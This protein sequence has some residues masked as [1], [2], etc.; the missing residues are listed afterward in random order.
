MRG[1]TRTRARTTGRT[2]G[3]ADNPER[4][5]AQG[6]NDRRVLPVLI[7]PGIGDTDR[8]RERSPEAGST[9]RT[10]GSVAFQICLLLPL[11]RRDH[12]DEKYRGADAIDQQA[13][14][15]GRAEMLADADGGNARV[16][17][18][19]AARKARDRKRVRRDGRERFERPPTEREIEPTGLIDGGRRGSEARRPFSRGIRRDSGGCR[20]PSVTTP[21]AAWLNERGSRPKSYEVPRVHPPIGSKPA[22][23][24]NPMSAAG[25]HEG[26]TRVA[27]PGCGVRGD[28]SGTSRARNGRDE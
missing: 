20:V 22:K 14:G 4:G 13:R 15:P 9:R 5:K 11:R 23:G 25:R 16:S 12:P 26:R 2:P 3:V 6:R 7:S 19:R 18:R 10:S 28:G 21:Q 24:D 1:R 8:P 17:D 27:R